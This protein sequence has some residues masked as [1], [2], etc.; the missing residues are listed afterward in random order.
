MKEECCVC[1]CELG[2]NNNCLHCLNYS[3]KT[4][5]NKDK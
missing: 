3:K 4:K 5:K 1:E 2:T